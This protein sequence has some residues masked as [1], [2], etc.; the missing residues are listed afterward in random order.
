MHYLDIAISCQRLLEKREEHGIDLN[1]NYLASCTRQSLG[2][3]AYPRSDLQ[4][5]ILWV[6]AGFLED[7]T[8]TVGIDQNI[9]TQRF[10]KPDA[11]PAQQGAHARGRR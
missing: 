6:Q 10:L 2:Q 8:Q 1:G 3:S 4:H 7:A 5:H 9:L 11:V